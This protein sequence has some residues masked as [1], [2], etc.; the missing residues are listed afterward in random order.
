MREAHDK[1]RAKSIEM[2]SENKIIW[3]KKKQNY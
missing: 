1:K 3:R 2:I